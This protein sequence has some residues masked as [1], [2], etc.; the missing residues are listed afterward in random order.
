MTLDDFPPPDSLHPW[1]YPVS[2]AGRD[3]PCGVYP[4]GEKNIRP[5]WSLVVRQNLRR[6]ILVGE[7]T[8]RVDFTGLRMLDVAC[9]CGFWSSIY[10]QGYGAASVVGI[11]G[12]KRFV[13]Q[14]RLLYYDRGLLD[15]AE[16]ICA[17][18]FDVDLRNRRFDFILCAG[19]LYHIVQHRELLQKLAQTGAP[20]IVID[21]RLSPQPEQHR[22]KDLHFNALPGKPLASIPT[23]RKI[24]AIMQGL[25]YAAE[26]LPVPFV[27]VKGIDHGDDY[28]QNRRATFLCRKEVDAKKTTH[29][30]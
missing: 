26:K 6:M 10:L 13:E 11:E 23:E 22:E 27:T 25:G 7:L 8:K 24:V 18:V 16:F 28:N 21:T 3:V 2:I 15:R 9:N 4:P 20:T 29:L 17:D 5:G 12:R 19:L 30:D 14:A 1:F